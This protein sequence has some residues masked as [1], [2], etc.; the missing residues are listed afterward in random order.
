MRSLWLIRR[1]AMAFITVLVTIIISWALM[2]YSPESPANTLLNNL[3]VTEYSNPRLLIEME[4]YLNTL[5]PHGNPVVNALEYIWQILHG[6]MGLDVISQIPVTKIIATAIPWTIFI[7]ST[8]L[9]ISFVI[10]IR[11]G[12][13]MGYKRGTKSDS[14]LTMLFTVIRSI[15]IYISGALLLF[16]LGYQMRLFPS[17]GAYSATVQVGLNLPFIESVLYHS[18]LPIATLTLANLGGWALHMRANTIYTLGEDY[19]TYAELRGITSRQIETK[20]VGRNALLPLY[21]SLVIA[22]G[23]SFGGSVFVEQIFSYP[24]IGNLLY[25]SITNN[26]YTLEMGIFIILITAVVIGVLLAD[27]TYSLIDPRVKTG[28]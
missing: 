27:L 19:V 7:V 3:R 23:F 2:E 20:Y 5:R 15:P 6:N 13:F 12:Q 4:Q 24:G 1:V 16:I 17:G 21:T 9:L 11:V 28:D 22:I 26:D 14:T 25:Y 8:S 18:I 10:G